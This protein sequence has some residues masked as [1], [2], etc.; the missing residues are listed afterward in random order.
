TATGKR[1]AMRIGLVLGAGGAVGHAFHAGVLAA[2]VDVTGWD[3]RDADVV[4]GTSAGSL[5][6]AFVRAGLSGP[7]LAARST[8]APM[9][10]AGRRLVERAVTATQHA[11]PIPSRPPR[12]RGVPAMSAPGAVVRAAL[13]PWN[14]RP[15]AFAAAALPAGRVS[16]DVIA[17]GLRPLFD[18][19]PVRPLWINALELQTGRRVTFGRG[20]APAA[21]VA[22]AVAASCAIPGFF[23]PVSIDGVRY[24]DGGAHSPTNADLVAGLGFDLV[25]ISSPMSV[26]RRAVRFAPD[27]PARRLARLALAREAARVR[28]HGSAVLTFQ[29]TADDLAVMGFNAMDAQRASDVTAQVRRSA[30]DRLARDDATDR[31]SVLRSAAISSPS[32]GDA[33]S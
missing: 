17:S 27:Q 26:A 16:T 31:V 19:W 21:D 7:D 25:V 28:H 23:A 24:V 5:V 10:D 15:G 2:L 3:A 11:A 14:V 32:A 29:P 4:V 1:T 13:W 33:G 6:G 12:R 20:D 8:D 9:S 30:A 22:D 18:R